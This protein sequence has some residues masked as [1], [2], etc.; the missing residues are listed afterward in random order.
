MFGATVL[1]ITLNNNNNN[2]NNKT[3][4]TQCNGVS[5]QS[6]GV[7]TNNNGSNNGSKITNNYLR[8]ETQPLR[9][10]K[11]SPTLRKNNSD[12]ALNDLTT[13][14]TKRPQSPFL[15]PSTPEP[16]QLTETTLT[17]NQTRVRVEREL[18][19]RNKSGVTDVPPSKSS[20][21]GTY[22]NLV[23]TIVGAGIIGIPY[24]LKESGLVMGLILILVVAVLTDKS[25][26]MLIET[27]K[28]VD[29]TSYERLME[30]VFGRPGFVFISMNMLIMSYGAM[31]CYML[32][33]KDTFP[34]LLGYE[35]D[36]IW[37]KRQILIVSSFIVILPLSMQR[38]SHN[39][40]KPSV[41]CCAMLCYAVLCCASVYFTDI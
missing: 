9:S 3:S 29:A 41:L 22:A 24:A 20:L 34:T 26:R 31:V 5:Q 36:D 25:L 35:D 10:P 18:I 14:T 12:S 2:N 15:R 37:A 19:L 11:R 7:T 38:V 13:I 6:N 21:L 16:V 30:A 1:G 40:Y 4:T 39:S 23:N 32:I 8:C 17:P 28:S 33:I 27:G